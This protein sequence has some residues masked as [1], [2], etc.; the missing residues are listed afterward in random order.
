M[1]AAMQQFAENTRGRDFFVGDIHGCYSLLMSKLNQVGFDGA[2]DRLFSVGDLVDRGPESRACLSLPLE[3]W[4]HAVWGNHEEMMYR[5]LYN[6]DEALWV[7]NGGSW[8]FTENREEVRA[9]ADRVLPAMPLAME[10]EH[11]RGRIGVIHAD[12]HSGRWGDFDRSR[13]LWSRER[14]SGGG[15]GPVEGIDR[16]VVGHSVLEEVIRLENVIYIDTGAV[17]EGQLQV[18]EASELFDI[19]EGAVDNARPHW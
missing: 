10:V 11:G 6:R 3:P 17:F 2:T 9:L 12:V 7:M 1:A 15:S 18:L 5:G 8:I 4:F 19:P 13:D 16:V 14:V